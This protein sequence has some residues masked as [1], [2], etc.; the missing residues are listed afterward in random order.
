MDYFDDGFCTL[1]GL[2]RVIYL[3]VNGTVTHKP[4]RFHPK[5]LKFCSEDEQSFYGLERHGGK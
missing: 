1:L 4:P 3:A 2:D 5:Y